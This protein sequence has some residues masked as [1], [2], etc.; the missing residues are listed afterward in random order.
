MKAFL[1]DL[2]GT[3]VD[4]NELHVDSWDAAFR[5][6]GKQFSRA[7][8]QAQIGKGSDKYLPEF[9]SPE[10]IERFGKEL[11]KYRSELFRKEYLPRVRPF[12]QVRP[13]FEEIRRAGSEI[14]LATSGKESEAKHYVALLE[15]GE[16]IS[17]KTTADD[18]DES[19][20]AP[21]I[22]LAALGKLEGVPASEALLIGDTRF[23]MQAATK[24]GMS[25][26]GVTCGGTPAPILR[27]SGAMAVYRDPAN[28]LSDGLLPWIKP[29]HSFP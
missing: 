8:L 15:I 1:F 5:H 9:L 20:P 13:L 2:D 27:A 17:G 23:D 28:L 11:D 10:E 22:L 26:I 29:T 3:L 21:D 18:A 6:F 12:P 4:S 14:V 19:K 24:A 16:L 7:Q 25:A